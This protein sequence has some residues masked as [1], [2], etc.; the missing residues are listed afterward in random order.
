MLVNDDRIKFCFCELE[1]KYWSVT[2]IS[3]TNIDL[4]HKVLKL[5]IFLGQ[6]GK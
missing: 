5:T 4:V 2:N 3:I 1:F 6:F